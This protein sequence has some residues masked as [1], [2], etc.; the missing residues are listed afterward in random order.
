MNAERAVVTLTGDQEASTRPWCR[1]VKLSSLQ[2]SKFTVKEDVDDK[3]ATLHKG[4]KEGG[5][6]D[7][8]LKKREDRKRKKGGVKQAG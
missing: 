6:T 4:E 2:R 7:R 3:K 8:R 1:R 5:L